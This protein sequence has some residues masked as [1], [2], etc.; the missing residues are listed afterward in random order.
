[1]K[2]ALFPLLGA[3]LLALAVVGA[4]CTTEA[5]PEQVGPSTD[6][7]PPDSSPTAAGKPAKEESPKEE[8]AEVA[9]LVNRLQGDAKRLDPKANPAELKGG[10]EKT[11]RAFFAALQKEEDD[12]SAFLLTD[13]QVAQFYQ[14][15]IAR[16]LVTGRTGSNSLTIENLQSLS[17]SDPF[18]IERVEVEEPSWRPASSKGGPL[19]DSAH[20]IGTTTLEVEIGSDRRLLILKNCFLTSEGWRFLQV[21]LD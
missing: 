13:E 12:P 1:M 3:A 14:E 20:V 5:P 9:D 10:L 18:R 7:S 19:A 8:S 21:E 17:S 11:A 16:I 6:V 2:P 4:G 15:S